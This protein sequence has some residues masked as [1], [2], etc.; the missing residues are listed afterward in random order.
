M[1]AKLAH[2]LPTLMPDYLITALQFDG[3]WVLLLAVIAAGIVRGFSGFGTAMVFVPI[4]AIVAPPV[5]VII[6]MLTF[7][8]LGPLLMLPRAWREGEP[9]DVGI[10]G[11]GALI[12]LP[13]GLYLLT[14]IDPIVFRWMVSLLAFGLLL[15]L[16]SGWRYRNPLN[17]V[18]TAMVGTVSGFLTGVAALPGP[19]VILSYMSSPRDPKTIRANTLMYLILVDFLTMVLM[20][21]KGMLVLVPV[22]IGLI[23]TV[24]YGIA[25]LIG[26]RIFDPEKEHIYRRV[27]Y[28]IIAMSA[29]LGL[30]IWG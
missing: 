28:V 7:D 10:L 14:R 27:A 4:A 2:S 13:V 21:I 19:P 9:K 8:L 24:P 1:M 18:K 26:Q 6:I 3:L 12:G 30:P 20:I 15:L 5:H 11:V 29:I 17:T 16:A 25:G 23:L 22:I